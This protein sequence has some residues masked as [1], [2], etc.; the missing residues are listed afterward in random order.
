MSEDGGGIDA[1][2]DDASA[3][4]FRRTFEAYGDALRR[5]AARFVRSR[6]SA[7]DLVQ[8]AYWRLWRV[9]PR[10]A[11]DTNVRAYLYTSVR[12]NAL[13]HLRRQ[14]AEDRGLTY[15][16]PPPFSEGPVLPSDGESQIAADEITAAV[17]RVVAGMP[18][19]QREIAALRLRDQ[20]STADIAT[21]L[22][23]SP[24]TVETHIARITRTL[25]EQLPL[26]LG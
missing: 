9:W 19:R 12:N 17:E 21:R 6:E 8:E 14:R 11:P 2:A 20:L 7:E 10:L 24:R 15:V 4:D 3:A 5:Y 16:T 1:R 26:L 25:R 22:G 23:I 18:S 13:N